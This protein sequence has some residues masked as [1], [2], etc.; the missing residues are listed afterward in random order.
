MCLTLVATEAS[1]TSVCW[2]VQ[3]QS[4]KNC[5]E[6]CDSVNMCS[7]FF[8]HT[9][10]IPDDKVNYLFLSGMFMSFK[11]KEVVFGLRIRH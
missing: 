6:V 8:S 10:V 4:L 3:F 1:L 2:G 7:L 9:T 11:W 5:Y